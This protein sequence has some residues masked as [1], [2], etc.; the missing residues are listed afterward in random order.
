[1]SIEPFKDRKVEKALCKCD[2]CAA[3][4][5]VTAAHGTRPPGPHRN[6]C[7]PL[8]SVGQVL[9]K[10]QRQGWVS[11]KGKLRCPACEAKRRAQE[12]RPEMPDNIAEIRQPTREQKREIIGLLTDTYDVAAER[13]QGAETDLTIA[14][15]IGGGCMPGW[16]AS[17]R[18]DMFGPAGA[19]ETMDDLAADLAAWR[20]EMD[21]RA[22][23]L[24]DR[25]VAFSADLRAFNA[26]REKAAEFERRIAAIKATVGPKAARL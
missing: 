2:D 8:V 18:E 11:V 4:V 6:V 24:H 5:A 26:E 15:A 20:A 12:D 23:E 9:T 16:V 3:Q 13:Y 19:N 22:A 25:H 1:M 14:E 17:I 7:P 10:I 21:A